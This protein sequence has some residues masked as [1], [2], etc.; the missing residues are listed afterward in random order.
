M[1]KLHGVSQKLS[2]M[3]LKEWNLS[4]KLRLEEKNVDR[5][6]IKIMFLLKP[7][8]LVFMQKFRIDGKWQRKI[9]QK[10]SA[11]GLRIDKSNQNYKIL[12]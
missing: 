1:T 11:N 8:L 6:L 3:L 5:I 2:E 4:C 9:N 12:I 7:I 10:L